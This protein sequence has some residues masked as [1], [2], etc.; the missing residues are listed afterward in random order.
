MKA[1]PLGDARPQPLVARVLQLTAERPFL[2]VGAAVATGYVL[3]G[4]LLTKATLRLAGLGLRLAVLPL[5]QQKLVEILES[6]AQPPT[7]H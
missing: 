3:G 5:L 4:G 7:K 1:P 2:A 6:T